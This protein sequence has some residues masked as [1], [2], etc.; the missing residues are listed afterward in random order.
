VVK[1]VVPL[2]LNYALCLL[3]DTYEPLRRPLPSLD[4][5]YSE[6]AEHCTEVLNWFN[7]AEPQEGMQA[8]DKVKALYRRGLARIGTK[9]LDR[10]KEDLKEALKLEPGNKDV[11]RE[12]GNIKELQKE[13]LGRQK[14]LWSGAVETLAKK[15]EEVKAKEE[16]EEAAARASR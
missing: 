7:P 11:R 3:K 4:D 12:L 5:R 10:A 9:D 16:A 15:N 8:P 6:A 1:T 14:A 2:R 13:D